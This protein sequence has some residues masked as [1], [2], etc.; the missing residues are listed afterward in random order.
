MILDGKKIADELAIQLKADC[1]ELKAKGIYPKLTIYSNDDPASKIY[2]RNKVKRCEEIGIDVEVIPA[3]HIGKGAQPS[4]LGPFIIQEPSALDKIAKGVVLNAYAQ[5]DVDGFSSRNIGLLAT[6]GKPYFKPCTPAGIMY[7]LDYYGIELE[8]KNALAIG[9]SNI[10]GRPMAMMLEQAGCTVTVAHSKTGTENLIF[11][12]SDADI[13]VSATGHRMTDVE[14]NLL[15]YKA[16]YD[17]ESL[18]DKIIIDVGM[19]RDEDGKLCGDFSEKF[20]QMAWAYTPVPGGVGPLTVIML[21]KNVIDF[22][23]NRA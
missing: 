10:V 11:L 18:N 21:C 5:S 13:I 22:Y 3:A 19:N 17:E 20:K 8:G 2:M 6:G 14:R 12:A 23:K 16:I 15:A 9:R 4:S 7:M 1:D